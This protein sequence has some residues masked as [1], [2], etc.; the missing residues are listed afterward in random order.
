[1]WR[2]G[3]K[4]IFGVFVNFVVLRGNVQSHCGPIFG[5]LFNYNA[6]AILTTFIAVQTL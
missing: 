3:L 5:L 1:M 4:G 2:V 6:Q